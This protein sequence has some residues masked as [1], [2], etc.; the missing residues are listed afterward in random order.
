MPLKIPALM[1]NADDVYS[2]R[3]R[4]EEYDMRTDE[5]LR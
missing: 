3:G 1:E 4:A 5:Y 2:A